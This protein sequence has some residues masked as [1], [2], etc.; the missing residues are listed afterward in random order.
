MKIK[1]GFI[2]RCYLKNNH[3]PGT[4][5]QNKQF[6]HSVVTSLKET[7]LNYDSYRGLISQT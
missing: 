4:L 2:L 1:K 3:Q 5:H 7:H 6:A